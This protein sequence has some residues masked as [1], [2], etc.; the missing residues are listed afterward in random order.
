[1][2]S[3]EDET[4]VTKNVIVIVGP[5]CSGKSH[6]A[7]KVAEKLSTEIISADSRQ[8]YKCL[9]IGTAKPSAEELKKVKHHFIDFLEPD[10]E[11]NVSRFEIDAEKILEGL[12][13]ESKMPIVAGGSGLYIK[14]L[15]DG[16]IDAA[17]RDD[18]YR[19]ELNQKRK[20]FGNEYLYKELEKVDPKSSNKMLPQ[21]WKR[22]MRALEVFHLTGEPIWMHHQRQKDKSEFNFNQ[23]GLLW[24]RETLYQNINKRVDEMI[25]NGLVEEVKKIVESGYDKNLNSLNTVGYK[26]VIQY[27]NGII[28]L[29]RAIELIKRNTRRYAKRQLTWFRKDNRIDWFNINSYDELEFIGENVFQKFT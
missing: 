14:A 5:T 20:E 8:F 24:N 12:L 7:I 11:Y 9:N 1:M 2:F 27:L 25:D 22:V 17:D 15:I 23:F 26:E 10:E 4:K 19:K 28:S 3:E 16:I 13:K 6:L 18:D 21:N 29:D